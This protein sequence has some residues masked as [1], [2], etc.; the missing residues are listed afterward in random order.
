MVIMAVDLGKART[1]L[2]ICD[3]G[4]MLSSPLTQ[5]NEYNRESLIEKISCLAKEKQAELIVV[6]LPKNM[7]GSEGE[8]AENARLFAKE[9]SEST[10]IKTD[11]QDERGTTITA[12]RYLNTTNTRGKK[13]KSVVD[14]LS[15]A[16]ILEDYLNRRKNG[17][18]AGKE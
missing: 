10:G 12:H 6:G 16:I 17:Y 18:N 5:I 9:L 8:S 7:D 11:M 2:A 1:G 13:R 14:T 4:E 3:K 15:A